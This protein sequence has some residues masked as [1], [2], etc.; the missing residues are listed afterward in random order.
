[1]IICKVVAY[2][3]W[4]LTTG[5]RYERV[6][7]THL[8]AIVKRKGHSPENSSECHDNPSFSCKGH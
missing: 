7:C 6:D 3:R 4:L 1:M 8:E 5:G 2:R